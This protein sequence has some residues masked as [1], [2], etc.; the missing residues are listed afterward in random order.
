MRGGLCLKVWTKK[1]HVVSMSTA[2]IQLYA[3]ECMGIQSVA[4]NLGIVCGLDLHL[5]AVATLCPVNRKGLGTAKH[6]DMQN[7]WIQE[8]SKSG[9]FATKKVVPHV[10]N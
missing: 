2:E 4:T 6:V 9:K 10:C 8:A 3:S 5:N 7:L 1:Q